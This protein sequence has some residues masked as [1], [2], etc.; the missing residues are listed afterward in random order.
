[1]QLGTISS[2]GLCY[3]EAAEHFAVAVNA[4]AAFRNSAI[5]LMY[6]ELVVVREYYYT[7]ANAFHAQLYIFAAIRVGPRDVVA[8][9]Q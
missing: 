7:T 4:S 8:N 2:N 6:E 3:N 1:V 9:R 5:H